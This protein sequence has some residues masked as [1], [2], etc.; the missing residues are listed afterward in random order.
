MMPREL[1][2][3]CRSRSVAAVHVLE[4]ILERYMSADGTVSAG[5]AAHV[6]ELLWNRGYGKAVERVELLTDSQGPTQGIDAGTLTPED[7]RALLRISHGNSLA[8]GTTVD[9]ETVLQRRDT[10]E[11]TTGGEGTSSTR[12]P[13]PL[14][15]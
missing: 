2:E 5:E 13:G 15:H 6:C 4:E 11:S 1:V 12:T 9:G 3:A 7:L 10:A 14:T 8:S